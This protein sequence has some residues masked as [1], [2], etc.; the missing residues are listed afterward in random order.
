MGKIFTYDAT[1]LPEWIDYN[2]HMQDAFYGLVFS[3][4]VDALQDEVGFDA[5]YRARTGCTIYIVEE[6]KFFLREVRLGA[7]LRVLTRILDSDAKRFHLHMQMAHDGDL[8]AA[9]EVIEMHV[10]RHPKP[11]G[12]PMPPEIADRLR[13]ARASAGEIAALRHRAR[14]LGLGHGAADRGA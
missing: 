3:R 13:R 2:D 11:H 6:H 5:A 7:R 1:V 14:A 4:A 12:A 8:V 10:N 9:S